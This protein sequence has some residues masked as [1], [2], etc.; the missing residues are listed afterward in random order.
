MDEKELN[1][2]QEEE[3]PVPETPNAESAENSLAQKI[4]DSIPPIDNTPTPESAPQNVQPQS[5]PTMPYQPQY[6]YPQPNGATMPYQ[7]QYPQQGNYPAQGYPQQGGYPNAPYPNQQGYPAQNSNTMPYQPQQGAYTKQ[8]IPQGQ[9]PK[10][11][12]KG[13]LI[14]L[15]TGGSLLLIALIIGGIFLF[16]ALTHHDIDLAKL[17][18]IEV[19]G[20]NGYAKAALVPGE[21]KADSAVE[22]AE[23]AMLLT[24]LEG[25]LSKTEYIENGDEII[26]TFTYDEEYAKRVGVR[27]KNTELRLTV[28]DLEEADVIDP[29]EN[30]VL[31]CEGI[32]PVGTVSVSGGNDELFYYTVETDQRYFK[33]GDKVTVTASYDEDEIQRAGGIVLESSKEYT[34]EGLPEY[35]TAKEQLTDDINRIIGET[36]GAKLTDTLSGNRFS[37]IYEIDSPDYSYLANVSVKN[38]Q[39]TDT[40]IASRKEPRDWGTFNTIFH[41][42]SMDITLSQDGKE[43]TFPM[44]ALVSVRNVILEKDGALRTLDSSAVSFYLSSCFSKDSEAL[45]ANNVATLAPDYSIVKFN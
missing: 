42:Y 20:Y 5:S 40:Y 31:T 28:Q 17:Y 41:A 12:R 4:L 30:V 22:T 14:G 27:F 13:L 26:A 23:Q 19:Q 33:N 32:S 39:L 24:T 21:Q 25:T 6:G 35:I 1:R 43:E 37:I 8:P 3:T 15:I 29:F 10:K 34:I 18:Q 44:Y 45:Y 38:V 9:P 11:S 2:V 36:T 16:D 7:Q